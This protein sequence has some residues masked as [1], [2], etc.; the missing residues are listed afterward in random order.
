M[1]RSAVSTTA[2]L[3]LAYPVVYLFWTIA[4]GDMHGISS[5]TVN[6][7]ADSEDYVDLPRNQTTLAIRVSHAE[8]E[9]SKDSKDLVRCSRRDIAV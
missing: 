4:G 5:H 8:N 1:G 2:T 6:M 9:D 7:Q 3:L